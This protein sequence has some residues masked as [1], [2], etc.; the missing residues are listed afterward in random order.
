MIFTDY[1]ILY[2]L[3]F[4]TFLLIDMVWLVKISPKFYKQQI[5]H[6]MAKKVNFP[7]AILFYLL[8]IVGIVAFVVAP[9]VSSAQW[10]QA[11]LFGAL[12]GL[13]TYATYDLTNMSTLKDWP[14]L[15]TIVDL[16]WGTFLTSATSVVVYFIAMAI[17]IGG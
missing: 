4:I 16:V 3:T 5:G 10:T 17:G 12:F 2:G 15:I 8:F 13:I 1:L 14:L 7:A 9:S 11:L 6:L